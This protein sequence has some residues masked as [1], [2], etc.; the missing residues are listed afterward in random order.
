VREGLS[1]SSQSFIIVYY[2][3]NLYFSCPD[4]DGKPRLK[5]LFVLDYEERPAGS[6]FI[7]LE[8]RFSEEGLVI[9]SWIRHILKF[10]LF[11][12]HIKIQK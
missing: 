1:Q 3:F 5:K 11:L 4:G 2:W 7:N 8:K 12:Q 9:N 10:I 6:S